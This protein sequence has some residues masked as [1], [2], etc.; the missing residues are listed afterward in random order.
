[1]L[2]ATNQ[3]HRKNVLRRLT[4]IIIVAAFAA[5]ILTAPQNAYAQERQTLFQW[6]F[7]PKQNSQRAAP[8]RNRPRE[9]TQRP[10]N[11]TAN[12]QR[13]KNNAATPSIVQKRTAVPAPAQKLENAKGVLVVGDFMASALADALVTNFETSASIRIDKKVNGSSG[14]VR[15]DYYNWQVQLP[16][17]MS[18]FKPS[19]TVVTI[20]ANDR[21]SIR[22][23][24]T[25]HRFGTDEWF[26][27]Y[28]RRLDQIATKAKANGSRL[29]W[30]GLPAFQSPSFTADVLI[31]NRLYRST[32][33]KAGG[34]FIDVW[35]GF[36]DEAGKFITTGFDVNG[37]QAR[38]READ[39]IA[40]TA[41]GRQKLAFYVER[42]IRRYL[43]D[44]SITDIKLDGTN[45]PEL[46]SLPDMGIN[47]SEIRTLP[48]SVTDPE[49]DGSKE[50]L[51]AAPAQVTVIETPRQK[52]IQ[53]GLLDEAPFGRID[54]YRI[55]DTINISSTSQ[56]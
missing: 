42:V 28:E 49:L 19:I 22:A 45:L 26:R 32:A 24:G 14:V 43:D 53:R 44:G 4:T 5:P 16:T 20:G 34:E 39:G 21:Q 3:S 1:M 2:A 50:L 9:N 40:L 37:Q 15:E 46:S 48:I 31:L 10:R 30:V 55:D 38:L 17:F 56:K 6:L 11:R 23:N 18:E 41:A 8:N 7:G 47:P 13:A 27:E 33:E 12:T 25:E 29:L 35:D 36:T 51:G 54:D 52:L